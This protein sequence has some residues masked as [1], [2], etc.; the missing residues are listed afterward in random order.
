MMGRLTEAHGRLGKA[1]LKKVGYEADIKRPDGSASKNKYGKIEDG[2]R[3]WTTVATERAYPTYTAGDL[4]NE[5]QTQG[6][7]I[8]TDEPV[9]A[10]PVDTDAQED[11]RVTM[12]DTGRTYT[13]IEE[14]PHELYTAFQTTLVNG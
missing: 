12:S 14:V 13:L 1:I 4:P 7:R 11:D 5:A 6:G 8:N 10:L 3:T 9:I 2:D